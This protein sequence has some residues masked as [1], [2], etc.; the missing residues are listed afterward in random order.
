METF[1]ESV[2]IFTR[3]LFG[4]EVTDSGFHQLVSAIARQPGR[5]C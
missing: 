1:D 5:M 4:L 3:E 2:G